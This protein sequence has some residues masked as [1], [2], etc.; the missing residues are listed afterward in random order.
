MSTLA[1]SITQRTIIGNLRLIFGKL[2]GGSDYTASGYT[3]TPA[4][5]GLSSLLYMD[6]TGYSGGYDPYVSMSAG[7]AVLNIFNPTN[8]AT[9]PGPGQDLG[10]ADASAAVFNF[11]AFGS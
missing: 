6:A 3:I 1:I 10:T 2:T 9:D 11:I 8:T 5:L 7:N 4:K